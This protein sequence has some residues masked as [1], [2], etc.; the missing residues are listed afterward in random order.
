MKKGQTIIQVL[1]FGTIFLIF[2]AGI[3]SYILIL[4]RQSLQKIAWNQALHIAEAGLNYYKWHLQHFPEDLQDGNDWCCDNPPC[5]VCGPYEHFYQDPQQKI[6]G[7]F[8]LEIEGKVQCGKV[9]AL[10]IVST[11]W[12]EKFPK[13]KRKVSI[14]YIHSTVADYAFILN[15]DVWAGSD[16]E[17]KGPYH[18]NGGIRMDGENNSLVTSAKE[19]WVCTS[20]FGCSACPLSSGCYLEGEDC[21]CPGVFTTANGKKEL[22]KYPV[23]P[24][25]FEGITIDLA[26]I[27]DLTA[28][29]GKGVYL[30]PSEKRGYHVILNKDSIKV[31]EIDSLKK[32]Y[33]YSLEEGWHWEDSIIER[34]TYLGE[35]PLSQECNLVFIEDDLWIEGE[36]Q[37]K[38]TVVSADLTSILETNVWL[39]ND[40]LY[41]TKNGSDSL[42]LVSQH[43]I[44]IPLNSPDNMELNGIFIAQTGRFGRNHY[45]CRWY[46]L[47]CVKEYLE[48]YGSIVSNGRVGTQWRYNWGGI[49]SGYKKRE[50]IYDP[51]QSLDPPPFL[52]FLSESYQFKNWEEIP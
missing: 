32:V 36:V 3:S 30:P 28:N 34:E 16:R 8:S 46:P 4:H 52:P 51:T 2:L 50:N 47:D 20:S 12:T 7:K 27:R 29:Q 23:A 18:S 24:F 35:Y 21:K 15:S 13:I 9:M 40:I 31:Y 11:G 38:L 44:L 39:L 10:R 37:G 33:S 17:I 6:K 25:D 45:S 22:F 48:I 26:E 49:A 14:N 43:N 42:L 1:I 41:T 5:S 19:E